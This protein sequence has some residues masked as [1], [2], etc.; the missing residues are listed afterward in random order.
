MLQSNQRGRRR[1]PSPAFLFHQGFCRH[2]ASFAHAGAELR[3][4]RE[5]SRIVTPA[6]SPKLRVPLAYNLVQTAFFRKGK[7]Y[8][9]ASGSDHSHA[10][11]Q[12]RARKMCCSRS[13]Q[14]CTAARKKCE[15]G[16]GGLREIQSASGNRHIGISLPICRPLRASVDWP[17]R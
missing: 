13:R 4:H 17:K 14:T 11:F 1:D 12:G 10:E 3:G 9:S 5:C 8:A 7:E 16:K 15:E 6:P 2:L